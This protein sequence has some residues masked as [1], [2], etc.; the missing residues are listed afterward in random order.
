MTLQE[1]YQYTVQKA[2]AFPALFND[3]HSLYDLAEMEIEEGGSI[4][5]EC[6]L[7]VGSIDELI[8]E[9]ESN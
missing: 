6:E 2:K 4:T 8:Q 3:I 7:A 9:H 1:L 5:H